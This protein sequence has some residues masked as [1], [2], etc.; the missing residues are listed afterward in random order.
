MPGI[1]QPET[2]YWDL[3]GLTFNFETGDITVTFRKRE[4]GRA[5][6]MVSF[7]GSAQDSAAWMQHPDGGKSW[8]EDATALTLQLALDKGWITGS[9]Y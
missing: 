7:N 3:V 9:V 1:A 5:D 6:E 4:D 2:V 8:A